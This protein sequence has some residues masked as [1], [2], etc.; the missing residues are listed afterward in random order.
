M[1][2]WVM[3]NLSILKLERD[4]CIS[5]YMI[6]RTCLYRHGSDQNSTKKY[7]NCYCLNNVVC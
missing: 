4:I 6:K 1:I 7:V 2:D 3:F 5:C